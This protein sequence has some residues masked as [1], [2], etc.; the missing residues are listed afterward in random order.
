LTFLLRLPTVYRPFDLAYEYQLAF[1]GREALAGSGF[2]ATPWTFK[3]PGEALTYGFF[4]LLFGAD[5]W[6]I[7]IRV[8]SVL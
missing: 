1:F 7:S 2:Y 4:Y 3:P 8:F 6:M 5:K